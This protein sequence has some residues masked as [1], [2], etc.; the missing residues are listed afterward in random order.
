[1]TFR[2]TSPEGEELLGVLFPG[3]STFASG[4][5]VASVSS[6]APGMVQVTAPRVML[7]EGGGISGL[8]V[9]S[10]G[11]GGTVIVHA[12]DTL[13]ISGAGS[14]ISTAS[15]GPGAGG[16]IAL[17]AGAITLAAGARITAESTGAGNAGRVTLSAP[18]VAVA[19]GQ[20]SAETRG[21]G[22]AGNV[23]IAASRLTLTGP[24]QIASSSLGAGQGGRV[25][26]TATESLTI[27][28]PGR[29]ASSAASEGAAG[30]VTVTT[31][32][33]QMDGA[34]AIEARTTGAGA[35]GNIEV[36][37]G[38]VTL[39][40]GA[41]ISAS[42]QGEGR[43]GSVMVSAT[44][45]M[46]LTDA[47]GLSSNAAGRGA[48]GS[49]VVATPRLRMDGRAA[50]EARTTGDGDA[51][52]IAVQVREAS[53]T[54][55][56]T[57]SSTSGMVD[58]TGTVVAGTGR[59]GTVT[60][61]VTETLLISGRDSG[62]SAS[63]V[64]SQTLGPG[65]AG[66]I[67]LVTPR[68]TVMEGGQISAETGGQGRGGDVVVQTGP[69]ALTSGAQITSGSGIMVGPTMLVGTGAGGTITVTATD[70]VQVTGPGTGLFTR[71][72]GPGLGGDIT[73]QA[74]SVELTEGATLSAASTGSGN[75]GNVTL[76]L[77]DTFV[78]THG[79]IV[80]RAT[81]AD[82]G[83]IQ[84]TAPTLVRLRDSA[85][86]A[87]VGGGATTVGGNITIDPQFVLLQNSQIIAN[88]F[89]GT[90]GNIRIIA[91]QV[92]LADPA[93]QVSASSA[94]GIDGQVNIQSP[95]TS[96]SGA[97]APLPQAFAQTAELL[98]TRCAERLR[99]GTVSRF[100]VGGRDGVPLEPGSLLLSPLGQVG[101]E[102]GVDAGE[103]QSHHPEAQPGRARY[104]QAS[105]P[106]GLEGECARWLG[107]QGTTGTQKRHR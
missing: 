37:A 21:P 18:T 95:V 5:F 105:A 10:Q 34:G 31:P 23:E 16:D 69:L 85:I 35:G 62:G 42:T 98:R 33:L 11:A 77:G 12:S 100:V 64:F 91:Q 66:R 72:A 99:E 44:E 90:G 17:H 57:I 81:Q 7:A 92:F 47:G 71:T 27:A 30:T 39:S 29:I 46:A 76:T 75:A 80:T 94:L 84:I 88:A 49:V 73:V 32:T 38:M 86:T 89:Q 13:A 14:S 45:A 63:G 22:N 107:R 97:V 65:D 102:G 87:E 9:A 25:E 58:A 103:R 40:R 2:G 61:T 56:A 43:G 24:A 20:I 48:A 51:G 79:S 28:G 67:T 8:N 78:S 52:N 82:G 74:P 104:A 6:G 54:G 1:M 50:I 4:A 83:N 26:V 41:E 68:L 36:R 60:V 101:Q 55:G 53:L 19:D 70:P 93:S 106:E 3:E 59:G 15:L 96:I